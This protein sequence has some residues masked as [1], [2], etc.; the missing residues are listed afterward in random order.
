MLINQ[1]EDIVKFIHSIGVNINCE[2]ANFIF[3]QSF[4]SL[5]ETFFEL[6]NCSQYTSL[7]T[8]KKSDI[9]NEKIYD[10]F[11]RLQD[12]LC[13]LI[14]VNEKK[15]YNINFECVER[16][17]MLFI[18]EGNG[19][20]TFSFFNKFSDII[21]LNLNDPKFFLINMID[22]SPRCARIICDRTEYSK[23]DYK[24]CK[25]ILKFIAFFG[26]NNSNILSLLDITLK[27]LLCGNV[28]SVINS[29]NMK[30]LNLNFNL[31][32]SDFSIKVVT[33]FINT[34]G[35]Q[36]KNL[37]YE[38]RNTNFDPSKIITNSK[39]KSI[40]NNSDNVLDNDENKPP[41]RKRVRFD[42]SEK[43]EINFI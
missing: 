11:I 40:E 13:D 38:R 27:S 20:G 22:V 3:F 30:E 35:K 14:T 7:D 31:E 19:K 37:S 39:Y 33:F 17:N 23:I 34:L 6:N 21:N 16:D 25:K 9:V 1:L 41:W 29:D 28:K 10:N 24:V 5:F 18:E 26:K 43:N 42:D 36:Q 15:D 2:D 12:E 8:L 4:C 32:L